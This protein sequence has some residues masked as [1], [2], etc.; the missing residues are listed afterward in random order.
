MSET[1]RGSSLALLRNYEWLLSRLYKKV[2][3]RSGTSG[4]VIPDPEVVIAGNQAI[5]RNLRELAAPLKRD[6]ELVARYLL[7]E[8]ATGGYYDSESSQLVLNMR[9]SGKVLKKILENF[10]KLYV[11]CP[12]CNSIDTRIEKRGRVWTLV[13]EACGAE[14]PVKPI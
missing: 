6:P 1:S 12:T 10:E 14:Q 13:C 8:L 11:R 3:P 9:I 7:K 5:V 2:P 4:L